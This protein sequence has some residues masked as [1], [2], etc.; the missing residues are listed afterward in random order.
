MEQATDFC[1]HQGYLKVVLDVRVERGGAIALFE[2]FGFRLTRTRDIDGRKL[3]DFF[4]DLYT[5]AP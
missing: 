2:K 5:S 1:R 4:L 3:H